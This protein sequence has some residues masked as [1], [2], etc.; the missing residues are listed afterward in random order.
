MAGSGLSGIV[1]I[2]GRPGSVSGLP[3]AAAVSPGRPGQA[4]IAGGSLLNT[5]RQRA[6]PD[7]HR[8]QRH[9]LPDRPAIPGAGDHAPDQDEGDGERFSSASTPASINVLV[10]S[11]VLNEGVDVPAASV[12]I[13][14]SGTGTMREHVQRSGAIAAQVRR[15]TGGPVR[16][17]GSR[18]GGGV[19]ERAAAA[20]SC[21]SVDGFGGEPAANR[22]RAA[23]RSCEC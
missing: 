4:A 22:L 12:G 3:G 20:A 18:Y 23:K 10:T 9:G 15:Q 8:R 6:D 17:G 21:V 11:Q 13:V 19:H 14:L 7:L 2:G 5:H 1:P 16:G